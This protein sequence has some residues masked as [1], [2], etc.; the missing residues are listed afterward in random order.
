MTI[1]TPE[2]AFKDG[3]AVITG[4]GS[5]IGEGL[6]KLAA[7]IGMKVVIAEFHSDRGRR[8]ADE[9]DKKGGEA[10]FVQT[11]V[12][13]VESIEN[14]ADVTYKKYGDVRLLV[15]CASVGTIGTIWETSAEDWTR[16]IETNV[17][18]TLHCVRAFVPRMLSSSEPAYIANVSSLAA[19]ATVPR[20]AP[21]M[22]TKSAQ[23]A[24]TE[25][26]HME[27]SAQPKPIHVSAVLPGVVATRFIQD[28]NVTGQAAEQD[29]E[30]LIG[31]M[32]E[33]GISIDVSAQK[34][35][36]GIAS[37]E[38]WVSTHPGVM[39]RMMENRANQLVSLADPLMPN[40]PFGAAD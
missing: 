10:L 8:V 6:A 38:F 21:Y 36:K 12:S 31:L 22:V 3:V 15:N 7:E 1:Q 26:L 13:S 39:S 20:N 2:E 25:C 17:G 18:G 34:I 27:M 14:L 23:L 24:L 4:A 29:R 30:R 32:S 19:M 5:G 11:D 16:V 33:Q 40:V 28:S 35:L 9:I 37:Q